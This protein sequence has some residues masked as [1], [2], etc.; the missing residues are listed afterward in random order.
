[1]DGI[2]INGM[3]PLSSFNGF[4]QHTHTHKMFWKKKMLLWVKVIYGTME[5]R[6]LIGKGDRDR[7]RY[8]EVVLLNRVVGRYVGLMGA[9][10][11]AKYKQT[12]VHKGLSVPPS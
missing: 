8:R 12:S 10:F 6:G 9:C 11:Y 5:G 7:D 1:M 2:I 4:L 3:K